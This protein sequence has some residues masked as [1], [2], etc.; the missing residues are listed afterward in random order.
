MILTN[1]YTRIASTG[2]PIIK[3]WK[4][5]NGGYI[6]KFIGPNIPWQASHTSSGS[7]RE[8]AQRNLLKSIPREVLYS[9]PP[10]TTTNTDEYFPV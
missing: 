1:T 10:F 7:T 8:E 5:V 6:A 9:M 4:G 3:T 2:D